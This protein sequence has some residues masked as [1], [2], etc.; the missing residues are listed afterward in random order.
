MMSSKAGCPRVGSA[1]GEPVGAAVDD[2]RIHPREALVIEAE[3]AHRLRPHVVHEDVGVL[4]Q[5]EE[6]LLLLGALEVEDDAALVAVEVEVGR[7]HAGVAVRSRVAKDVLRP[8]TR[9]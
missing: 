8:G 4:H 7:A 1:L 2:A 3:L 9:P 6:A 5:L